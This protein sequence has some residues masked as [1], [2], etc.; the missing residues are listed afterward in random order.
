[1]RCKSKCARKRMLGG[2]GCEAGVER[3][4]AVELDGVVIERQ[5]L[6][7]PYQAIFRFVAAAKTARTLDARLLA[8]MLK[9]VSL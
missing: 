5:I 3:R 7:Q 9:A 8:A 2:R 6:I 4:R 1:M